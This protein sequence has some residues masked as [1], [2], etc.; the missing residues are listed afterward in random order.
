MVSIS[1]FPRGRVAIS[2]GMS[3]RYKSVVRPPKDSCFRKNRSAASSVASAAT[4]SPLTT[5]LRAGDA[6]AA[7]GFAKI[8]LADD[9]HRGERVG[10]CFSLRVRGDSVIVSLKRWIGVIGDLGESSPSQSAAIPFVVTDGA[11]SGGCSV[12]RSTMKSPPV[13][14]SER[15]GCE[16]HGMRSDCPASDAVTD[17]CG[18]TVAG[19]GNTCGIS[20]RGVTA[21]TMPSRRG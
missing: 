21:A 1:L 19:V 5:R 11:D 6:I 2:A 16:D 12:C 7:S 10:D 9:D 3:N 15:V 14:S 20:L 17:V 4:V 18:G 8:G 13:D